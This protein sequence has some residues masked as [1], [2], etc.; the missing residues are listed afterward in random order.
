[1][2]S[3]DLSSDPNPSHIFFIFYSS[4]IIYTREGIITHHAYHTHTHI[5]LFC[6]SQFP[7]CK[8]HCHC[9]R[10]RAPWSSA[11]AR[12]C[13]SERVSHR[14]ERKPLF[15]FL[16]R[17]LLLHV[18]FLAEQAHCYLFWSIPFLIIVVGWKLTVSSYSVTP[19][20]VRI[21]RV[22]DKQWVQT[23][24]GITRID[25]ASL[26]RF[27]DRWRDPTVIASDSLTNHVLS[28]WEIFSCTR[29]VGSQS[30]VPNQ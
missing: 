1:M 6:R 19:I 4:M 17:R 18:D 26:C 21:R 9:C 25:L 28:D 16:Q 3:A 13:C 15:S 5:F 12:S 30:N 29:P 7:P 23:W 27:R 11:M 8:R 14:F 20:L 2:T 24:N 10:W 22:G